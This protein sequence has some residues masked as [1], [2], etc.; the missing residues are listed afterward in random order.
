MILFFRK[1]LALPFSLLNSISSGLMKKNIRFLQTMIWRITREPKA[2]HAYVFHYYKESIERGR[3]IADNILQKHNNGLMYMHLCH[4]DIERTKSVNQAAEWIKNAEANKCT[5]IQML[6]YIKLLITNEHDEMKRYSEAIL[7]RND[8]PM[9]VTSLAHHN[10]IQMYL[11]T[12]EYQAAAD[13]MEKLLQFES[14]RIFITYRISLDIANGTFNQ[15]SDTEL[16]KVKDSN[17]KNTILAQAY[18]LIHELEKCRQ[19][20]RLIDLPYLKKITMTSKAAAL[21]KEIITEKSE[22]QEALHA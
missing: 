19:Y 14:P 1:I 12:A 3:E 10:L 22:Q 17:L 20:L 18:A 13:L 15:E 16:E 5:D 7:N 9:Y 6:L 8:L 2:V 11:E 4:L 21:V